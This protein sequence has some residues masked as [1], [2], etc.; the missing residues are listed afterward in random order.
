MKQTALAILAVALI[1]GAA[2]YIYRQTQGPL[3][4]IMT[5]HETA[6]RRLAEQTVKGAPQSRILIVGN[7]FTRQAGRNRSIYEYEKRAVR[8]LKAG[9]GSNAIVEQDY[10]ELKA[11][12]SAHPE[13][14][15]LP[16]ETTSPLSYMLEDGALQTLLKMHP[17]CAVVVSLIGLPAQGSDRHYFLKTGSPRLSLMMPDLRVWGGPADLRRGFKSGQ[18]LAALVTRPGV[19]PESEDKYLL[20]TADSLEEAIKRYPALFTP[21]GK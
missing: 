5:E 19:R 6:A 8:G 21:P 16:Q 12:A 11:A 3:A 9:F 15:P 17:A 10:P 20:I 14:F 13:N 18:L 1:G 2:W 7:P 4:S